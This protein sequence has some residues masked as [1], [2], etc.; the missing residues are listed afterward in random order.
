VLSFSR[1]GKGIVAVF[2]DSG[3][4]SGS[5]LGN[6]GSLPDERQLAIG[7]LEFWMLD[8]LVRGFEPG[9]SR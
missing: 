6:L 4:F 7:E 1:K 2:A 9:G 8:S 3:L 5:T